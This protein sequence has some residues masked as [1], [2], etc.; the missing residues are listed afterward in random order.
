P[1]TTLFRS[2]GP[3]RLGGRADAVGVVGL[4]RVAERGELLF[5]VLLRVGRD[6][7]A[8]VLQRLF[9]RVRERVALIADLDPLAVP[10]ILFGVG[11]RVLDQTLD[12]VLAEAARRRD[13]HVLLAPGRL[14]AGL[15]VHD[16]V[17][18][19]VE[20]DLD[21]RDSPGRRRESC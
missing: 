12:L 21:L 5:D 18:I 7:V 6:L 11:L 1:Y 14:V 19:D 9:D 16:A 13:G 2:R 20:G 3:Q 8:E 10:A 17:R 4:K 15:D